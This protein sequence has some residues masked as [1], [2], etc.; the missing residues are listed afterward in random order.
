[1]S[2]YDPR[3]NVFSGEEG[4]IKALYD[5][6]VAP[7]PASCPVVLIRSEMV[8]PQAKPVSSYSSI[9]AD[10][11][12][13]YAKMM[14][15]LPAANVKS[16]PALNMLLKAKEDGEI[17]E[18]THTVV[19]SSSGSTIMSLG[20][21]ARMHGI[22][23]VKAY[24]SNK[25][26]REKLDFLRIHVLGGP[27][28][29]APD[30][31]LNG[32]GL[33]EKE[34]KE[35]GIYNPN[36]YTNTANYEAHMRW[37][38]PQLL[39]QLPEISVFCATMGT[40]G[41]MTGTGRYLKSKRPNLLRVGVVTG[42]GGTVPGPRS[43][44]LLEPLEFPWREGIEELQEIQARPSFT[45]ALD[46]CRH[47]LLVGPSSGQALI[48]MMNVLNRKK[49]DGTLDELRNESG[50]I[51]CAFICADHMFANTTYFKTYMRK[52]GE[53][54]FHVGRPVVNEELLD[55]DLNVYSTEW[56]LT[57]EK[58]AN[59]VSTNHKDLVVLD[60][61][62]AE[63]FAATHLPN[64]INCPLDTRDTPNP[65]AD[66]PTLV[67]LSTM[68]EKRLAPTDPEF[69]HILDGKTVLTLSYKGNLALLAMAKLRSRDIKA[70][71][72]MGGSDKWIASGLS[73]WSHQTV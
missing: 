20:I 32:I 59:L 28:Q 40:A 21:M 55:V 13:L 27:S 69:G 2:H 60:F 25:A 61:R 62:T 72:V 14:C 9:H 16:L 22:P 41:T 11:V 68:V 50:E 52:M 35:P 51:H 67:K 48:G 54:G 15:Y 18:N 37:T 1:M 19:E 56:E 43:L 47:G 42:E 38:G 44:R 10:G 70:H 34:G 57:T 26:S 24:F 65:Y 30:D 8:S 49:E 17:N 63:D 23:N 64:A 66:V 4:G 58:A 39:Q 5:P 6:D 46:L 31:P 73:E 29:P 7:P 36:Q 3:Y 71:C 12:R 53:A 33:A 45:A